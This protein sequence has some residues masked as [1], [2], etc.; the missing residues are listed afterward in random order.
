MV[1]KRQSK[2]E[3]RG[4][5]RFST[6]FA[7]PLLV[8]LSMGVST[9]YAVTPT[10]AGQGANIDSAQP[11]IKVAVVPNLPAIAYGGLIVYGYTVT[12]T[13][14]VPL[15]NVTIADDKCQPISPPYGGTN[16]NGI[17]SANGE[18]WMYACA[19]YL[20]TNTVDTATV[21]GTYSGVT[22]SATDSA[23]VTVGP[24]PVTA[25]G[26]PTV[27]PPFVPTRVP[28]S[29]AAPLPVRLKIPKLK[30]NASI[31]Y[32]GLTSSGALDVPGGRAF[33]SDVAWYKSGPRPGENGTAVIDGHSG[34]NPGP[35]TVFDNLQ[36]LQK[37]DT[38]LVQ[39]GNGKSLTFVVREGRSYSP[40]ANAPEVFSSLTGTHLNLITC[41]WNQSAKAFTKRYVVFAD[42]QP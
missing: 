35:A 6:R 11:S 3:S 2:P 15:S 31:Q 16:L 38:L 22:V 14:T 26:T 1:V 32:V 12:N 8:A 37:G 36:K 27:T 30:I 13:G 33:R 39:D 34:R 4:P 9:A 19:T 23:S 40:N 17:L 24:P 21:T 28:P 7:L 41:I 10:T 5:R 29:K 42:L 18:S 20:T 25:P